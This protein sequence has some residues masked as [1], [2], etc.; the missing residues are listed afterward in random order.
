M[1]MN[2][3][4]WR[5]LAA[6]GLV[7]F[8]ALAASPVWSQNTDVVLRFVPSTLQAAVGETFDVAIEVQDVAGLYGFDVAVGFD[9]AVLEVV[10]LDPDLEGIQGALGLFLDPGFV[11][12]NQADNDLGQLRL[13]MTQLN[14]SE[15]R[16][17][18]G[19]LLVIRFRTRQAG[20]TPLLLLA[21]QLAQRDGTTFLPQLV[22]GQLTVTMAGVP[23]ATTTPIPAQLAGTP[24]P[25]MTP[26]APAAT[27]TPRPTLT[28][29]AAMPT[30]EAT[31][32][33]T[34]LPA[35]TA[36]ATATLES[37]A[38]RPGATALSPGVAETPVMTL[39][40]SAGSTSETTAFTATEMAPIAT[41][42]A[43]DTAV[44]AT[45]GEALAAVNTP[46]E[47]ALTASDRTAPLRVIG[48]DASPDEGGAVDASAG[49]VENERALWLQLFLLI[50]ALLLVIVILLFFMSRRHR[51]GNLN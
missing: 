31:P 13:A 27:A 44:S 4:C 49:V 38:G 8:W 46:D 51:E 9:P 39:E 32:T 47:T 34:V 29:S 40:H 50:I 42:A 48:S 26:V 10:D 18:A 15:A 35:R 25:T 37:E 19:N 3:F 5:F 11:I 16:S 20:Q 21:G 7:L 6:A 30:T 33:P 1:L 24:L 23:L 45:N 12:I 2:R 17:G 22:N 36:V 28:P 43:D 14:P 41:P